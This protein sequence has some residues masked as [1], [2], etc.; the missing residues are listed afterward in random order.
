VTDR[1]QCIVDLW[2][3]RVDSREGAL[4]LLLIVDY[5]FDWARDIYRESIISQLRS[6]SASDTPSLANDSDIYSMLDRFSIFQ[7]DI[8]SQAETETMEHR[9]EAATETGDLL[10]AFD[11]TKGAIREARYIRSSFMSLYLTEDN[12][13]LFFRSMKTTKDAKIAA[14]TIMRYLRDCWRVNREALDS[15]ETYWTGKDRESENLYSP[16]K[17]FLVMVTLSAYLSPSW[18]QTREL[19]VL[20][21]SA[22]VIEEICRHAEQI[23]P[24]NWDHSELPYVE[25]DIF[26]AF[27]GSFRQI[28]VR[29]NLIAAIS[30]AC[31]STRLFTEKSSKKK[32]SS[33][34]MIRWA[35]STEKRGN[36]TLYRFDAALLPDNHGSAREFVSRTYSLHKIGRNE[37]S[38][39]LLR[40]SS[41]LDVQNDS[42]E[43]FE[44]MWLETDATE[45][46]NNKLLAVLSKNPSNI[47][48]YPELCLFI[49]DSLSIREIMDSNFDPELVGGICLRARRL[50]TEPGWTRGWNDAISSSREDD[51]GVKVADL[52]SYLK[53]TQYT[54]DRN[55]NH[56]KDNQTAKRQWRAKEAST[57]MTMLSKVPIGL[58]DLLQLKESLASSGRK[59]RSVTVRAPTVGPR[60]QMPDT[61]RNHSAQTVSQSTFGDHVHLDD[62]SSALPENDRA[63]PSSIVSARNDGTAGSE[64]EGPKRAKGRGPHSS[65]S[66]ENFNIVDDPSPSSSSRKRRRTDR[67]QFT[68][69]YLNDDELD[70]LIADGYFK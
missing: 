6:L 69:N 4:N 37:P 33:E 40:I 58:S 64:R 43:S 30:R 2:N 38:S 7:D 26:V 66:G 22:N 19:S 48:G 13:S 10:R 53:N 23:I 70:Q 47:S 65:Y 54:L 21:I 25:N 49:M 9:I 50:A 46:T 15:L 63:G 57:D 32:S 8:D 11:S 42:E 24:S 56:G 52:F 12:V 20:A 45:F 18:E 17:V 29:H 59:M 34:Q 14:R 67:D 35:V 55:N 39:S 68:N 16:T 62:R 51:L 3:G 41:H 44:S 36:E 61:T 60:N 27:F 1:I 28:S 31:L 5:I